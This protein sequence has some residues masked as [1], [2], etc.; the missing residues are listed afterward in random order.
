MDKIRLRY[1][2][3]DYSLAYEVNRIT[4]GTKERVEHRLVIGN[5]EVTAST[6]EKAVEL[7]KKLVDK[8]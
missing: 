8:K 2:G 5:R 3:Q 7:F 6:L 4:D 1:S